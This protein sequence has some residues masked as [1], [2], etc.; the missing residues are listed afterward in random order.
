MTRVLPEA[1]RLTADYFCR[2]RLQG[3]GSRGLAGGLAQP[4]RPHRSQRRGHSC[5]TSERSRDVVVGRVTLEVQG[6]EKMGLRWSWL[7]L[8]RRRRS[9]LC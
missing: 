5:R 9:R 8:G 1:P 3:Y 7:F 4:H 2:Q 6:D